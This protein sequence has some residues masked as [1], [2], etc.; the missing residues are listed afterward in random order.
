MGKA[1]GIIL[2]ITSLSIYIIVFS[3]V[4]QYG[5]FLAMVVA[6][7]IFFIVLIGCSMILGGGLKRAALWT[8]MFTAL[9]MLPWIV[10][11]PILHQI[12]SYVILAGVLI[13]VVL[14]Y[15]RR[16]KS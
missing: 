15:R 16:L 6:L 14:W 4:T 10:V 13:S 5:L 1:A 8:I 3:I 11:L 9:M 2:T 7:P 12:V